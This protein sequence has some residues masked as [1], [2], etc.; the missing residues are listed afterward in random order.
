M[1]RRYGSGNRGGFYGGGRWAMAELMADAV[2][3]SCRDA[4]M[5][6]KYL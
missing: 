2:L 6:T 1:D 3:P 5:S 4:V